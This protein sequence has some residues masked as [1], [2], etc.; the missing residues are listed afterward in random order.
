MTVV[1]VGKKGTVHGLLASKRS[2]D[3]DL[4]PREIDPLRRSRMAAGDCEPSGELK[5]LGG[6]VEYGPGDQ[7]TFPGPGPPSTTA[8][9]RLVTFFLQFHTAH[10]RQMA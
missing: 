5:G 3:W 4:P 10:P 9:G 8:I 6:A 2:M 7:G 1:L